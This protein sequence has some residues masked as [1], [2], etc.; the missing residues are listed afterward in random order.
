[1]LLNLLYNGELV[2]QIWSG[3]MFDL[4]DGRVV[5][6]SYA[7]WS[8]DGYSLIAAPEV[9]PSR[10]QQAYN[11]RIFYVEEA[12]P[13]FFKVQRGDIPESE[14]LDKIAEIKARFPYPSE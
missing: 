11:R 10:E 13:L 2:R 6:P 7:G 12:D 14:W 8:A 9:P 5:S 1:M 3:I 4:P